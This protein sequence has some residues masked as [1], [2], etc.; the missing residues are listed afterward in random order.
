MPILKYFF[1]GRFFTVL[2]L[3]VCFLLGFMLSVAVN[4]H[5][6]P[7]EELVGIL[8]SPVRTG[9]TWCKTQV[10]DL[11]SSIAQYDELKEENSALREQINDLQQQ[12]NDLHYHK[13]QNDR[14]KEMLSITDPSYSFEYVSADVVTVSSDG[15][16][17]S[18]G[19]NAGTGTGIEQG[20]IV[21]CEGG[22]VGK[23]TEV[24]LNWSTV[25]TFIDPQISVGAM[26]LSTG[27]VGVTEG[28]LELKAKGKCLVRYL[29][30]DSAVNRGDQI[31]TSGLGGVYP[32]GLLLGTVSELQYED[33]GLSLNA[34]LTPAVSFESLK[35][36]LVITNFSE[37]AQ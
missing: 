18:F 5:T 32:K 16:S 27:D 37:D 7:H 25:S 33:N 21:V 17:G 34:V 4:G 6:M 19:I 29:N 35:E 1:R 31:Y 15:W 24:G 22:L 26:I 28:R 12:V 23:V 10:T 36:V 13:V 11:F 8:V 20:D 2:V 9:F 3:I 30:K 14:Y